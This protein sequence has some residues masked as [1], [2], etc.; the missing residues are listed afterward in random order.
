MRSSY[1][2]T[3]PTDVVSV[4]EAAESCRI[5]LTDGTCLWTMP[6]AFAKMHDLLPIDSTSRG[7]R[8]EMII[9]LVVI[10]IGQSVIDHR[11]EEKMAVAGAWCVARRRPRGEGKIFGGKK[12][13]RFGG[14]ILKLKFEISSLST[15]LESVEA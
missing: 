2:S 15:T 11:V 14:N 13:E 5:R 10:V 12:T 8:N 4:L 1:F 7:N 6:N 9:V 3:L